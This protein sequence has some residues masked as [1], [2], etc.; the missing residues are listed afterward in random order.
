MARAIRG[1]NFHCVTAIHVREQTQPKLHAMTGVQSAEML[2]QLGLRLHKQGKPRAASEA[3][4]AA[5]ARNPAQNAAHRA[6][7]AMVQNYGGAVRLVP[8]LERAAQ[9][10]PGEWWPRHHLGQTY[11]NLKR[12]A[13][14]LPHLLR[15]S[16]QA[17][18]NASLWFDLGVAL[19]ETGSLPS[20]IAAYRRA[21]ALQPQA[22]A[23]HNLASAL[24]HQGDM[25][26]AMQE[27]A[28]AWKFDEA[29][30]PRIAQDLAAGRNGRVWLNVDTLKQALEDARE[31]SF[32]AG[33]TPSLAVT[34]SQPASGGQA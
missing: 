9:L 33:S 12:Y 7:A 4:E 10:L 27:Y 8:V 1:A 11:C 28:R 18:G 6:L 15:A 21:L 25:A 22:R 24:Q 30:L 17:P 5:I 34:P 19:Q 2:T 13:E 14:A 26:A 3:F 20:A 23:H 16:D 32:S 29:S 31:A